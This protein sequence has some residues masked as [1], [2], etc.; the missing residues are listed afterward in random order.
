MLFL[1]EGQTARANN[2]Q[3][4]NAPSDIEEAVALLIA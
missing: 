3:K 4:N 2:V 1:T